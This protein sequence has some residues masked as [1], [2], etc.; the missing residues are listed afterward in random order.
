MKIF[1]F[2]IILLFYSEESTIEQK[3]VNSCGDSEHKITGK[4]PTEPEHCK[5]DD[6]HA[7]KFV[8]ITKDGINKSFCAIIHGK[9]NDKDVLDE[10]KGLIRADNLEVLESSF[11]K[12]KYIFYF[13][14]FFIL[15]N[16]L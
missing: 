5:D 1:L 7:C 2:L 14:Y 16:F 11:I 9:F 4:M 15:L 12:N 6:E 3:V 8:N 10:V 13:F